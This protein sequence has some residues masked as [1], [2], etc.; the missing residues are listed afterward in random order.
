MLIAA[1]RDQQQLR[2]V[3]NVHHEYVTE[4]GAPRAGR[5]PPSSP[6]ASACPCAGSLSSTRRIRP[7][8]TVRPPPRPPLRRCR[9][10]RSG[11]PKYPVRWILRPPA[12][13]TSARPAPAR[14]S[15]VERPPAHRAARPR[16]SGRRLRPQSAPGPCIGNQMLEHMMVLTHLSRPVMGMPA[17]CY[18]RTRKP[19]YRTDTGRVLIEAA[20][21][22][23]AASG[24]VQ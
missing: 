7:C 6:R 20:S 4:C 16:R 14:S 17:R 22:S 9:R 12:S 19:A 24:S 18:G 5:C 2:I 3:R 10:R 11:R 13:A 23:A 15:A 21:G 1:S 8:G